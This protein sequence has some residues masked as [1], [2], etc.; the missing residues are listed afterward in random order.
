MEILCGSCAQAKGLSIEE[1][2]VLAK[3]RLPKQL[4]LCPSC[5]SEHTYSSKVKIPSQTPIVEP[6]REVLEKKPENKATAPTEGQ[7]LLF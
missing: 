7:M 2:I 1:R 3:S 5:K 6:T 4:Y